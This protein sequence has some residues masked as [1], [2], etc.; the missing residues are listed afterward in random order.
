[1]CPYFYKKSLLYVRESN[2]GVISNKHDTQP[3]GSLWPPI[4]AYPEIGQQIYLK[5]ARLTILQSY[6]RIRIFTTLKRQR[7]VAQ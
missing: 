6:L 4:N 7:M 5:D 2:T 1:M 3:R